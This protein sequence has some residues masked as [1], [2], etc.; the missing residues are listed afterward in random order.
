MDI[1]I[2]DKTEYELSK[3]LWLDCFPEDDSAFVDFYYAKRSKPEYVLGAFFDDD[4]TPK[5]MMHLIPMKMGF[6]N[7]IND[8]C[9][10]AGVCTKPELRGRGVCSRLFER[11]FGLM[12]VR[13]F[14]AAV[15]Q[16]FEEGFYKRFGFGTFIF[17][18]E[19]RL[20]AERLKALV[21]EYDTPVEPDPILLAE[22]YS[23]FMSPYSGCSLRGAE[24]FRSFIEEFSMPGAV[25]NV[26]RNGCCAG[27]AE[28]GVFFAHELFFS[29]G[30]DPFSLLPPG[31]AE[32]SF[33]LP[34]GFPIPYDVYP[35]RR[36]FSMIRT[37][38]EG[39][40]PFSPNNYGFDMY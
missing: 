40:D 7:G 3:E 13:G 33:P 15:L 9:F 38:K 27:Y 8:I 34:A 1:R 21:R 19:Y 10:V 4:P 23:G 30:A 37:L 29:D 12:T 36:G 32:Y 24:Y 2:L 39:F 22:M 31:F 14:D 18:D 5:A 28:N 26:T 11:A 6:S 25:L 17:R 16:P 20:S 35:E